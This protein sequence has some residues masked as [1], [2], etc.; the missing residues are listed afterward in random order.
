MHNSSLVPF[1]I[2]FNLAYDFVSFLA[3]LGPSTTS[4]AYI[5]DNS[6]VITILCHSKC[7]YYHTITH[8]IK[9]TFASLQRHMERLIQ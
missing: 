3:K 7:D 9:T 8:D 6:N 4:L 2:V 5:A 1:F